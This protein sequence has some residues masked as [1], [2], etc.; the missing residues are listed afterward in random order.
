MICPLFRLQFFTVRFIG[1][2]SVALDEL[3]DGNING[4]KIV[5]LADFLLSKEY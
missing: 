2:I 4:V 5:H 3:A 1:S